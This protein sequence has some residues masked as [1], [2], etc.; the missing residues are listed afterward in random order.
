MIRALLNPR[1]LV[2]RCARRVLMPLIK[3]AEEQAGEKKSRK[4]LIQINFSIRGILRKKRNFSHFPTRRLP[5]TLVSNSK[6]LLLICFFLYRNQVLGFLYRSLLSF[7]R[8]SNN[9]KLKKEENEKRNRKDK[10]N[11]QKLRM[12]RKSK[13]KSKKSGRRCAFK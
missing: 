4:K 13:L 2:S 12:Q 5:S 3:D 1:K 11:S 6:N 10:Q 9:S 8:L 7:P